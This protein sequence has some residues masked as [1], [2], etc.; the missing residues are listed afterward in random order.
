MR[1]QVDAIT[2]ESGIADR[3]DIRFQRG[4]RAFVDDGAD[5]RRGLRRVADDELVHCAFDQ[6]DD[7]RR[8][9]ALHAQDA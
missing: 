1:R 8:D 6:F 5:V 9:I 3:F 4:A 7:P 2:P